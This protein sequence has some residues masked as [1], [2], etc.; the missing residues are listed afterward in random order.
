MRYRLKWL[1]GAVTLLGFGLGVVAWPVHRQRAA[2]RAL[3]ERNSVYR[4]YPMYEVRYESTPWQA[5]AARA[6]PSWLPHPGRDW[7]GTVVGLRIASHE[8]S[9]AEIE[10]ARQFPA[11]RTLQ[12]TDSVMIDPGESPLAPWRTHTGVDDDGAGRLV[13]LQQLEQLDLSGARLTDVGAARLAECQRLRSLWLS[14]TQIGDAGCGALAKL[15][16]LEELVLASTMVGDAGVATLVECRSLRR[17]YVFGPRYSFE[18]Q[19]QFHALRP[20]VRRM[21]ARDRRTSWNSAITEMG[22][23]LDDP[24]GPPAP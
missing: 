19:A 18:G 5:R 6:W 15:P 13:E 17:L 8:V 12:L 1:L 23:I 21:S 7:F 16:A 4:L 11:L 10:L 2:L 3:D 14:G 20:D 22:T 9:N 24:L